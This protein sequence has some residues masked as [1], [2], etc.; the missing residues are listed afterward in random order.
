[1]QILNLIIIHENQFNFFYSVQEPSLIEEND[2]HIKS[3]SQGAN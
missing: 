2:R 3:N 1:M